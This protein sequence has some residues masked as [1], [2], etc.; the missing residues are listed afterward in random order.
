M[1]SMRAG[2][3]QLTLCVCDHAHHVPEYLEVPFL[4]IVLLTSNRS[5]L[6][7]SFDFNTLF[8]KWLSVQDHNVKSQKLMSAF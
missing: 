1:A 6:R 3:L 4:G 7:R 8:M 5:F 2:I